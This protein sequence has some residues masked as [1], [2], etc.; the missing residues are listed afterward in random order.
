M[1]L[2]HLLVKFQFFVLL[3][4]LQLASAELPIP[5]SRETI[6]PDCEEKCGDVS[7]PYPFGI[8]E[9]CFLD[10]WFEIKCNRS[11]N[12]PKAVYGRGFDVLNIS[13]PDGQMTVEV[14]IASDCSD[15]NVKTYDASARL[16]KFIFS[17]TRNKFIA[18][19]CN[20]LAYLELNQ[21]GIGTGCMSVCNSTE[22]TTNGSCSGIGCCEASIPAGLMKYAAKVKIVDKRKNFGFNP[23]S[24]AFLTEAN[25]FSFS[26]S[27]LKDF[28]NN[29]SGTVPVVVDWT[30]GN[31]SCEEAVK[32]ST[33]YACG[34]NAVCIQGSSTTAPGYR[35]NCT[36]GYK[37][38]PYLNSFTGGCQDIDECK[39]DNPC[40]GL[41]KICINTMGNYNCPCSQEYRTI[42]RNDGTLEYDCFPLDQS[43]FYQ[44]VIG[45]CISFSFLLVTCFWLYWAYRK[46]K[47]MKLKV[48]LYKQ[49]GGLF[50]DR[51]LK[52][53]E[54]D[55]ESNTATSGERNGRSTV[56]I[57]REKDLSKATNNYHESQILGQGGFGT[58]YKGTLSNGEVVAIKKTKTVDKKQ[59]EQFINEI[60][61]L[62]QIKH[63]N[64]VQL[65]GC[66]LESDVPLL[67]Y[68]FIT[69]GTLFE[70]LHEYETRE[71]SA[72]LTWEDRLRIAAEVA[73]SLAY[74]HAEAII[75]IIHR[76]VKSSNIL[77]DSDYKAKV[78]D[79]GASRLIPTDQAQLSTLVQGTLGYLDPDYYQSGLLTEKSDV[80]SFG[81]LLAELL[82]GS[83]AVFSP[84]RTDENKNLSSYF[85]T[86]IKAGRLFAI[87][88]SSLVRNDNERI[89]SVHG[90]QQIEQMAEL[91]QK[92]L[93]MKGEKR[94]TMKEVA[95]VLHGL[96]R[97][98][99]ADVL[100]DEEDIA[101]NSREE[102]NVVL[103][104][105]AELLSYTDSI[106]TIGDTSRGI[107]ALE[108]EGR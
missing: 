16:G 39:N 93:R 43:K 55:I 12:P 90:N 38:N 26:S 87:L 1:A 52:E 11:F 45:A 48:E 24:Y 72:V 83:K 78:A 65:L 31:D 47:H 2:L 104:K 23:C 99:S 3:L 44:I 50:L 17:N 74:L 62:S 42:F 14:Y 81:V 77:L 27:Y 41:G 63:R 5:A 64:V 89:S 40:T 54:E 108:T 80:Y 71:G 20:T 68:E 107:L 102:V 86:S 37:G 51:L 85:L 25:S 100:D 28:K 82:T 21:G 15:K 36:Q 73:G 9:G 91:A 10:T 103:L 70:H 8:G 59:N 101:E 94:P 84:E 30:I 53:R 22:D 92:C 19:G 76:D 33:S 49:N 66:C 69:N 35:C 13:I 60:V 95:M 4:R 58:V 61:V 18:I 57:Y 105:S 56:T 6:K 34:P 67:V 46:R 79:F 29:G 32:N 88:D 7:I 106:T 97:M 96:M 98:T 75:P